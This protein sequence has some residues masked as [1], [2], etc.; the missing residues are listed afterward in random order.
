VEYS[1]RA[2]DYNLDIVE[3]L[4]AAD[5]DYRGLR[6]MPTIEAHAV[7]DTEVARTLATLLLNRQMSVRNEYSFTL[8][9]SFVMVEP[10]DLLSLTYGTKGMSGTPVRVNTITEL[11]NGDFEF[12][13]EDAPIGMATSPAY[14]AEA[15]SGFS[16]NYNA[17]PGMV[18]PPYIFEAPGR[19][20]S[21][22][23]EVY[24]AVTGLGADWGGCTVWVSL[25]GTDYEIMG[26][27]VGGSR[28]GELT[29]SASSSG[30]ISVELL[31]GT[32]LSSDTG[33]TSA[34]GALAFIGGDNKEYLSYS[35][36]TLTGPL[37]YDLTGT[38]VRGAYGTHAASHI[39]GSPFVRVD[40]AVGRSGPLS[41]GYIGRT[42]H[43][44]FTSFNSYG[45]AEQSLADVAD[46]TYVPTGEMVSL[47]PPPFS[48]IA[49]SDEVVL[50]AVSSLAHD[51]KRLS[52]TA[53]V[54]SYYTTSG[55]YVA[56][57][58]VD[59]FGVVSMGTPVLL[60][61]D[62]NM[63]DLCVLSPTSVVAFYT[64]GSGNPTVVHLTVAGATITAGTPATVITEA[65]QGI[66]SIVAVSATK[67][68][69]VWTMAAGPNYA[70]YVVVDLLGT[71]VTPGTVY[72]S[73]LFGSMH[74]LM[75]L[76]AT[77]VLASYVTSGAVYAFRVLTISGSTVSITSSLTTG[78]SWAA[79]RPCALVPISPVSRDTAYAVYV[80]GT[81]MRGF[82]VLV[83]S[84]VIS[85]G[86]LFDLTVAATSRDYF[87]LA[88]VMSNGRFVMYDSD[89]VETYLKTV[90]VASK[91]GAAIGTSITNSR[92]FMA[93]GRVCVLNPGMGLLAYV[94]ISGYVTAVRLDFTGV[95]Q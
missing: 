38:P 5:I 63:A 28:Y 91:K 59:E 30:T 37:K 54:L 79:N 40:E 82:Q 84:G 23:L 95:I 56:V 58:S 25:N 36:A 4:D 17:S 76:T 11:D 6:T 71:T 19:L 29:A 62:N 87:S 32:L 10:L 48:D 24:T 90:F 86:G 51:I 64:A 88:D 89:G 94:N 2:N 69:A 74:D 83:T 72:S 46:Y 70:K 15:G 47:T 60:S 57:L 39:S 34:L 80:S 18:E 13:C 14:G 21:T 31:Q 77:T 61:S 85:I 35:T 81:K 66:F 41:L 75:P 27:M 33:A 92:Y 52:D 22:G 68:L 67:M 12:E 49:S 43:F 45:L 1:N 20:S 42:M 53:A 78:I 16:H 65:A 8:P 44:K 9:W 7:C 55:S 26:R 3:A 50:N 73:A 93:W